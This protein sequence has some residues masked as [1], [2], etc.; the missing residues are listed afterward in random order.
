MKR[1][2]LIIGAALV[3]LVLLAAVVCAVVF[4]DN[5]EVRLGIFYAASYALMIL[6][7]VFGVLIMKVDHQ[8]ERMESYQR[9][10][11]EKERMEREKKE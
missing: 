3:Y 5:E 1:L 7:V 10:V 4:V 6:T 2:H 8:S 11:E 9:Y